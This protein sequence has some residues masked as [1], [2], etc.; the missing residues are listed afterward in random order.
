VKLF[1]RARRAVLVDEPEPDAHGDDHQDDDRVGGVAHECR[2]D[3]CAYEENQQRVAELI[4]QNAERV[5]A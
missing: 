5:V 2:H 1:H 3:R 4:Q